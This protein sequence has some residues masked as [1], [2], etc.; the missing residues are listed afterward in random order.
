LV[1]VLF[2]L[3]PSRD[4]AGVNPI[5]NRVNDRNNEKQSRSFQGAK[6]AQAQYDRPIPL[7]GN[8]DGGSDCQGQDEGHDANPAGYQIGSHP[9]L[10]V[11]EGCANA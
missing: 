5:R 2:R 7:V 1:R 11:G 9:M 4:D 10:R 3:E 6:L 8:L